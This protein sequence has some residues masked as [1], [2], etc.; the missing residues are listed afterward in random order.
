MSAQAADS[1]SQAPQAPGASTLE[2]DVVVY[3][4]MKTAGTTAVRQLEAAYGWRSVYA[5]P[6]EGADLS[7]FQAGLASSRAAVFAG[8]PQEHPELW[9]AL[10]ARL[11]AT[12]TRPAPLAAAF[13]RHPVDRFLSCYHFIK[14]SHYVATRLGRFGLS[15]EDAL[16]CDDVRLAGNM[17]TKCLAGLGAPRDYRRPA[18]TADLERAAANLQAME[19]VGLTER[20]SLSYAMLALTLGFSPTPLARWNVN[21]G[22]RRKEDLPGRLV[23]RITRKNL[24]DYELYRFASELFAVRLAEGGERLRAVAASLAEAP[25]EYRMKRAVQVLP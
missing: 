25:L 8:H 2:R 16:D 23:A 17:M 6:H 7:R 19:V 4:V 22:Y 18:T 12:S 5:M 3:H 21:T 9:A 24:L 20:F 11:A 13:L 1:A 15:L 14:D 10:H